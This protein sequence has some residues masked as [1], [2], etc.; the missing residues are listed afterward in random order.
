[1][2]TLALLIGLHTPWPALSPEWFRPPV[3]R[4]VPVQAQ[5]LQIEN[6][7]PTQSQR[8]SR[9]ELLKAALGE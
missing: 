5:L 3:L 1:M 6:G 4:V 9:V 7:I 8:R 2:M